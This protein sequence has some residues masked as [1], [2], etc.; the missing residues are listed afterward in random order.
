MLAEL[1]D[2][3]FCFQFIVWVGW[4]LQIALQGGNDLVGATFGEVNLREN[5]AGIGEGVFALVEKLECFGSEAA[6]ANQSASEE[7]VRPRRLRI[8]VQSLAGLSFRFLI[9][10]QQQKR[11]RKILVSSGIAGIE[12][13]SDLMFG[14]CFLILPDLDETES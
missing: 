3:A 5:Q 2:P 6:L 11:E 1:R 13:E 9:S 12:R 8:E 7:I 4:R 14:H 10:I